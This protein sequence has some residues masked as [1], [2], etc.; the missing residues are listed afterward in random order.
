M[1]DQIDAPRLN[2]I[3]RAW[4][5][6][7]PAF[8]CFTAGDVP[9]A[10]ALAASKF[11]GVIFEYEHNPFDLNGLRVGLQ[12]MLDRGEIARSGSIAPKVTPLARVPANG[13]EMNQWLAKQVLDLGVYGVVW[14]HVG[15]VEQAR[16]AVAACRYARLP[17]APYYDPPGERGDGPTAAIR[18]WGVD[19]LE[20]YRRADVWPLD[21][22]GELLVILMI[23]HLEGIENLEAMLREVPGIGAIMIGESDLSQELGVPRQYEHPKVLEQMQRILDICARYNVPVGHP[24]AT[25]E[26][27]E[28]LVAEGYRLLLSSPTL[29]YADFNAARKAAGV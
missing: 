27:A 9:A 7:R 20:Y 4:E 19:R 8:G 12:F 1:S 24:H 17:D 23:E 18:Y 16:N 3:I 2:G 22:R 25:A 15:T 11:D 28:R 6:G 26:N 21:P 29:S 14:P 5:A 13:G 10:I